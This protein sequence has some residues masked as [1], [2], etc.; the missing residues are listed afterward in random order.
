MCTMTVCTSSVYQL[1]AGNLGTMLHKSSSSDPFSFYQ[2]HTEFWDAARRSQ[3]A[4]AWLFFPCSQTL[5]NGLFATFDT[6]AAATPNI[7]RSVGLK[8]SVSCQSPACGTFRQENHNYA[9]LFAPAFE[10]GNVTFGISLHESGNNAPRIGRFV[11][12]RTRTGRREMIVVVFLGQSDRGGLIHIERYADQGSVGVHFWIKDTAIIRTNYDRLP[13]QIF[14]VVSWSTCMQTPSQD[15]GGLANSLSSLLSNE[16]SQRWRERVGEYDCMNFRF[17][18]LFRRD[19]NAVQFSNAVRPLSW[20]YSVHETFCTNTKVTVDEAISD[21]LIT[22]RT[23]FARHYDPALHTPCSSAPDSR[24]PSTRVQQPLPYQ[25]VPSFQTQHTT[26]PPQ[27]PS[28]VSSLYWQF[29]TPTPRTTQGNA[30]ITTTSPAFSQASQEALGGSNEF[31]P[32]RRTRRSYKNSKEPPTATQIRNRLAAKRSNEKKRRYLQS[33]RAELA[34]HHSETIPRLQE[35][36]RELKE[37][38]QN[39]RNALENRGMNLTNANNFNVFG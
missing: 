1:R 7:D 24:S 26:S 32:I 11:Q 33:V 8:C 36:M 17:S 3:A 6:L 29:A 31:P 20:T 21:E 22:L 39:L 2:Q 9:E 13:D 37:E 10:N 16:G 35:R 34:R 19:H 12:S 5:K 27:A 38:N 4:L 15:V 23:A 18:E 30:G 28:S 25:P 14:D